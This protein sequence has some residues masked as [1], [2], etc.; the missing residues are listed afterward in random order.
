MDYLALYKSPGLRF[1]GYNTRFSL[2]GS[3]LSRIIFEYFN[4]LRLVR[5]VSLTNKNALRAML[6]PG[7]RQIF[8]NTPT[9]FPEVDEDLCLPR[10][11]SVSPWRGLKYRPRPRAMSSALHDPH[12]LSRADLQPPSKDYNYKSLAAV[13]HTPGWNGTPVAGNREL[14]LSRRLRI[15]CVFRA[16]NV[17]FCRVLHTQLIESIDFV[18]FEAQNLFSFLARVG[19]VVLFTD[20]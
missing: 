4:H 18:R 6:R 13:A 19:R 1:L 16:R 12:S 17:T 5:Q 7:R 8:S 11:P 3:R 9:G 20:F 10:F 2:Q 15:G 14:D